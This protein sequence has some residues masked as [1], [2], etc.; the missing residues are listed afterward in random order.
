[1]SDI[2]ERVKKI[3]VE[4]LGVNEEKVVEG[5]SFIGDLGAD[6]LDTVEL[7]M[8]FEEEFGI[9]IKDEDAEIINTFGDAVKY[10]SENS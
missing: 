6:S 9:E 7:V 5:A 8:A 3:V 1:M 4:H 2:E 10:V